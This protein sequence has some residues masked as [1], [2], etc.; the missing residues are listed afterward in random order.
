MPLQFALL[1]VPLYNPIRFCTFVPYPSN[2]SGSTHKAVR[3]FMTFLRRD[4]H[5]D[6][7]PVA[8][9]AIGG[10]SLITRQRASRM[11]KHQWDA[12]RETARTLPP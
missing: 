12:V 4:L 5:S 6:T 10:N 7:P 1:P 11:C 9:V 3:F 2:S 8:V